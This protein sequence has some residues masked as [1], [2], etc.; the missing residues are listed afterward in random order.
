MDIRGS[1]GTALYISLDPEVDI[2]G[3]KEVDLEPSNLLL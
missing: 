2:A 1:C 3:R